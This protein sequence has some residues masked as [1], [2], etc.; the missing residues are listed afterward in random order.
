MAGITLSLHA[1]QPKRATLSYD[2]AYIE[3]FEYPRASEAV[4]TW[5]EDGRKEVL[6][7]GDTKMALSY[8]VSDM[9]KTLYTVDELT[10]LVGATAR[11][12]P[13]GLS[14]LEVS[15]VKKKFKDKRFAAKIDRAVIQ[16]GC[17]MLGM[18]LA[19]VIGL[20]IEGMR[21]EMDAL[22]LGPKE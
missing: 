16:Q 12:R 18:D 10:G 20:C 22:G 13:G 4:I 1:K 3:I 19:D 17:D 5:T 9:E 15:S 21:T 11:M 8:E 2:R 7:E 14:D 6:R